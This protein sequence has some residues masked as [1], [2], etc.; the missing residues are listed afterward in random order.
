[1]VDSTIEAEY[2]AASDAA[3][4]VVWIKNFIFRL[5]VVPNIKNQWTSIM[6]IMGLLFKPRSPDNISDPNTY[7]GVSTSFMRSLREEM[8]RYVEFI[9][10]T[11]LLI[12]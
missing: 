5:A 9:P 3:K 6:T 10:M 7:S 8:L 11:M 1:M 2:I 12:L 4:E